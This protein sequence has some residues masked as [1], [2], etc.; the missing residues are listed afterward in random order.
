MIR[1]ATGTLTA[2]RK[3]ATLAASLTSLRSAGFEPGV[4][5]NDH[6]LT[7]CW[8]NWLAVLRRLLVTAPDADR[9]LITEDDCLFTVGLRDYLEACPPPADGI[10]SLYCSRECLR[11]PWM[12]WHRMSVPLFAHGSLA[13][14][15]TPAIARRIIEEPPFP[16]RRQGT[17]HAIGTFCRHREIPYLVHSPSLVRHSYVASALGPECGGRVELRQAGIFLKQVTIHDQKAIIFADAEVPQPI[18]ELLPELAPGWSVESSGPQP[19]GDD[20]TKSA[21][22]IRSTG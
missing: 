4:I 18:P 1:W 10:T 7:G 12:T 14:I 22:G 11:E 6:L 8:Q 3:Q 17:D 15:L 2:P 21:S 16:T 5:L 20:A 13:Y 9:F 19:G